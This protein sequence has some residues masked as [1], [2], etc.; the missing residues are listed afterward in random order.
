MLSDASGNGANHDRVQLRAGPGGSREP[1]DLWT[2]TSPHTH[3]KLGDPLSSVDLRWLGAVAA[4]ALR[5]EPRGAH[6]DARDPLLLLERRALHAA[7]PTRLSTPGEV[8][9]HADA[10]GTVEMGNSRVGKVDR[11]SSIE[12]RA[13]HAPGAVAQALSV[14]AHA[15]RGDPLLSVEGRALHASKEQNQTDGTP[16]DETPRPSLALVDADDAGAG[17]VG[18][19]RT[20]SVTGTE[21]PVIGPAW[22]GEDA[23][24][25]PTAATHK[26]ST[27]RG[28]RLVPA[29][30]AAAAVVAG[31]GGGSA[32]AYVVSDATG[33][34]SSVVVMAGKPVSV[35][36]TATTGPGDLLPGSTGSAYF[37][38]ENTGSSDAVFEA[39]SAGAT[40]VSNNTRLC[41]D[42]YVSIARTLPYTLPT[43][44]TVRAGG[45]T[46]RQTIAGLVALASDAPGTC[47]GVTFT[48]TFSLSGVTS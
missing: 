7:A 4:R 42:A 14:G 23:R 32:V 46:G 45:T 26:R 28:V 39:I 20:V 9:A 25:N 48:V 27:R 17:S 16:A 47:Q 6:V 21:S 8:S 24:S 31:L 40:I 3:V 41:G 29:V 13:L 34:G 37:R 22:R 2:P 43:P 18:T 30:G 33:Q 11:V 15:K 38:L 12:R 36:V 44:L 10:G 5:V 35:A 1:R 19:A